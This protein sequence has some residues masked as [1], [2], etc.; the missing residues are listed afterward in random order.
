[1]FRLL[2]FLALAGAVQAGVADERILS[3]ESDITVH[4][5]STID[6]VET[7]R[8]RAEGTSIRRGIYRDFPTTYVDRRGRRVVTG[9]ELTDVKRDGRAEP[10]HQEVRSNGVRVYVGDES[11]FL[12]PGEYTY[13]IE[14][15]TDR[16]LG[17][18]PE[19]DELYWNVTGNGWDFPI[20]SVQ[21]RVHLPGDIPPDAIQVE[22]YTGPTGA[23]GRDWTASVDD[24]APAYRTTRAL[25]PREGLTIVA[26]WPR[27]FVSPPGPISQ[28]G[29]LI[30]DGWPAVLALGGLVALLSYY[31]W[32]WR[33][34]GRDPPGRIVVPR[35]EAPEGQSP[36]SMR[37][38]LRMN[39]DDRCFAAAV[40]S[41]A[42]KGY[43]TIEESRSGLFGRSREFALTR[44]YPPPDEPLFAD[45]RT[46]LDK[47]FSG[48][49]QLE[50]KNENHV[51]V[52]AARE[53]HEAALK[54]QAMPELFRVNS[55][56]Q[57][58]GIL[59]AMLLAALVF[60]LPVA[61]GRFSP[62][63]FLTGPA[64][65]VALAAVLV[66]L[67]ATALFGR[68][69]KAPT[70]T[71]RAIM[72]QIQGFRLFLDVAEGDDLRLAGAPQ[73]TP[74]L[75]EKN[76]P[77]ALA[78]GV[79]HQWA[80]RFSSVFALDAAEQA[81]QWYRGDR[82]STRQLGR[83]SSSLASS[84]DSAI[85]S[86]ASAPGSRSGSGGGGSSGGGGGGGGGGGW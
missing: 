63:W 6:V 79:E 64:G 35:Y 15:R 14:Y 65:W 12:S 38:L 69:L 83:F 23:K 50:L 81:P 31:L 45:E 7:L 51:I 27:G 28:A 3:Y 21:A 9:F 82:W 60:A 67:A 13:R 43:L 80:E 1:M 86:A 46:L 72:D 47:L 70:V 18:F 5:D 52:G 29:Y 39:Y 84:L 49:A 30:R 53:G 66:A 25:E 57:V 55:G 19:H 73:M 56:W 26:S 37:Y 33:R 32:A 75:F 22:A 62:A 44:S 34:I 77:A 2:V 68:L 40:L 36:A 17:F 16:Q 59:L 61:R 71:G 41:L 20:D 11:L 78:L 85:S 54:R 48:P 74:R 42:V 76:L 4:A 24:G 58:V 10:H 8:V